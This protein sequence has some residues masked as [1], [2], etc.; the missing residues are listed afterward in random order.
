M[1]GERAHQGLLGKRAWIAGT[2]PGA[3]AALERDRAGEV[4]WA[5]SEVSPDAGDGVGG[6]SD[7]VWA[8]ANPIQ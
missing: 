7:G 3:G 1:E 8:L 2:A 4:A 6:E 5:E